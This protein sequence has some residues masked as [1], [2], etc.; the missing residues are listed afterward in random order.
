MIISVLLKYKIVK[1]GG[2]EN[3]CGQTETA[4]GKYKR[5]ENNFSFQMLPVLSRFVLAILITSSSVPGVFVP[6]TSVQCPNLLALHLAGGILP[7]NK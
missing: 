1:R 7:N 3:L 6:I 4:F 5:E 2:W